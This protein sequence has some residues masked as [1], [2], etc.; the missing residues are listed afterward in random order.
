VCGQ[1]ALQLVLELP[2]FLLPLL[3]LLLLQTHPDHAHKPD[4]ALMV[5][6]T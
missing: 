2:H 5:F 1:E 4:L 6:A 3:L